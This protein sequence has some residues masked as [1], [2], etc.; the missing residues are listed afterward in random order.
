MRLVKSLCWDWPSKEGN[1]SG[2]AL[3]S[4]YLRRASVLYSQTASRALPGIQVCYMSGSQ[5]AY[6]E[7][8]EES[9]YLSS[10]LGGISV[11]GMHLPEKGRNIKSILRSP[12]VRTLIYIWKQFLAKY[13]EGSII[14]YIYGDGIY[15]VQMALSE[16]QNK[17]KITLVGIQIEEPLNHPNAYYYQFSKHF[18]SCNNV[19][20]VPRDIDSTGRLTDPVFIPALQKPMIK[21]ILLRCP[22]KVPIDPKMKE[23]VRLLYPGQDIRRSICAAAMALEIKETWPELR[24]KRLENVVLTLLKIGGYISLLTLRKEERVLRKFYSRYGITSAFSK[25]VG[26]VFQTY[27]PKLSGIS[28]NI[29]DLK[30]PVLFAHF[31]ASIY[32]EG[33]LPTGKFPER[34]NSDWLQPYYPYGTFND[35]FPYERYFSGDFVA[36]D[37]LPRYLKRLDPLKRAF[38]NNPLPIVYPKSVPLNRK[39]WNKDWRASE[40]STTRSCWLR[41]FPY[42]DFYSG[43]LTPIDHQ[44]LSSSYPGGIFPN[45]TFPNVDFPLP[46]GIFPAEDFPYAR[47]FLGTWEYEQKFLKSCSNSTLMTNNY[48]ST[49]FTLYQTRS[50]PPTTKVT[51]AISQSIPIE[52]YQLHSTYP[53]NIR[54]LYMHYHESIFSEGFDRMSEHTLATYWMIYGF[55]QLLLV[56]GDGSKFLRKARML[57]FTISSVA[58]YVN[59]IDLL[60]HLRIVLMPCSYSFDAFLQGSL[61]LYNSVSLA[62]YST[63]FFSTSLRYHIYRMIRL[64]IPHL[65]DKSEEYPGR[66]VR[67]T[68]VFQKRLRQSRIFSSVIL[69][70]MAAITGSLLSSFTAFRSSVNGSYIVNASIQAVVF[71]FLAFVY[72]KE[73]LLEQFLAI[74]HET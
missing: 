8:V 67:I 12:E 52:V 70:A 25:S 50:L 11:I 74:Y 43:K 59:V 46:Y 56:C 62:S 14:Q 6:Q 42:R 73:I 13:P 2:R 34:G 39:P 68:Q 9:L 69:S 71:F 33:I 45:G 49:S 55:A 29:T 21:R 16:I 7:A 20:V 17:H 23:L 18:S 3:Q 40:I 54:A 15:P 48:S 32:P 47:F 64:A 4:E 57:A 65:S 22:V 72:I 1:I 35:T 41:M 30:V 44:N 19:V 24:I 26:G 37:S 60:N 58:L 61:I 31:P 53:P 5:A 66:V 38:G 63:R 27:L 51:F 10:V 28:V 36:C